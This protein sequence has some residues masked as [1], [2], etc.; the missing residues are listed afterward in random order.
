[1]RDELD[2]LLRKDRPCRSMRYEGSFVAW[3][4]FLISLPVVLLWLAA[5]IPV[6]YLPSFLHFFLFWFGGLLTLLLLPAVG[7]LGW[8]SWRLVAAYRFYKGQPN[9]SSKPT[10]RSGAA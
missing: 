10:P 5:W 2:P 8:S 4:V 3:G 1:M 6:R 7:A 9:N